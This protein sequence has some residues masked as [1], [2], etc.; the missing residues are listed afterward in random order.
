MTIVDQEPPVEPARLPRPWWFIPALVGVVIGG[1]V[2]V[3]F[4]PP[5]PS[6]I[7]PEQEVVERFKAIGVPAV[8]IGE[9]HFDAALG[10]S[11][12]AREFRLGAMGTAY[13]IF[14]T[15]ID[16]PHD[17]RVC[18]AP[19]DTGR[20]RVVWVDK[21]I[22]S[23]VNAEPWVYLVSSQYFVSTQDETAASVAQRA[24]GVTR[25]TC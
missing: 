10:S 17:V 7:S 23:S 2:G 14:A 16:G 5:Q 4:L 22:T 3:A 9:S 12:P 19:N 21:Q 6:K 25:A 18:T 24:L 15:F 1:G 8:G 20:G 11:F 13:V